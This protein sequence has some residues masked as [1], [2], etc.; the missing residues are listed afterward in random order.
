MR[1]LK[2]IIIHGLKVYPLPSDEYSAKGTVRILRMLFSSFKY[3]CKNKTKT[4][5]QN[6]F[7]NKNKFIISHFR[8]AIKENQGL[9]FLTDS[10]IIDFTKDNKKIID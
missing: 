3:S 4:G 9:G 1:R 5:L 10:H 8:R 6:K 2:K 7:P